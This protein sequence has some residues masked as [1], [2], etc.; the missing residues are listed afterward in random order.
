MRLS[1][2]A[3]IALA[4]AV[5][6]GRTL[7]THAEE[8]P[9]GCAAVPEHVT[10]REQGRAS[11]YGRARHGKAT[12]DGQ[13]MDRNAMTAAH[14]RLPLGSRVRVT[15]LENGRSVELT[16]N[17]RGPYVRGRVIDVSQRAAEE[18]GFR[19]SGTARVRIETLPSDELAA[20]C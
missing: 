19:Q 9:G 12:A 11:W 3:I 20:A 7:E 8:A 15:N 16:I 13:P 18:L 5:A 4:A 14:R 1:T 2:F 6:H 17:D 10:H